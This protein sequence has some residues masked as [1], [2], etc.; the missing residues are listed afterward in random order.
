MLSFISRWFIFSGVAFLLL[1]H[2]LIGRSNVLN[3]DLEVSLS[4]NW[5]FKLDPENLGLSEKWHLGNLDRSDWRK[6]QIPHTWQVEKGTEEYYGVAWY[7]L[8]LAADPLWEG[9]SIWVH[10]ESI[11]RDALVWVNGHLVAEHMGSGWTPFEINLDDV[12]THGEENWVV[13]RV[14]N[15]FSERALPYLDSSDWAADG[16]IIRGVH[17]RVLPFLHIRRIRVQGVPAQKNR[18][19]EISAL[20]ELSEAFGPGKKFEV[21][22]DVFGPEGRMQARMKTDLELPDAVDSQLSLS[23]R[24]ENPDLWHFDHPQLYTL[25]CRLYSKGE[26]IHQREADFGIRKIEVRGGFYLLNGEP[27]R[28]M[29]LEWMPGSDPR[30]GMAEPVSVSLEVL[31]DLKRLNTV[32]TR[33]HWQQADAIYDFCDREGILVQEEVPAWGPKTMKGD[34]G[35]VQESQMREMILAHY[36]HPSIYAWGLCNE[37]GGQRPAAH[38]FVQRG[39]DIARE[40]DSSRLLTWASNT[41]QS[42]PEEDASKLVDFMEWNDYWE[43]WYGGGLIDLEKNLGEIKRAF[44]DKSLVISEYGLCE[45]DPKNPSGDDRRIE[46]LESHTN[47]YR[48]APNVAGAIF[49]SYNDYRTHIGDKS[50]GSFRQRV[51]G[52]VDL[53]GRPKPSWRV[54]RRESSPVKNL[55]VREPEIQERLTRVK[56]ELDTRSLQNDMPAYTLREYYLIWVVYNS[57]DQPIASGKI[58]LPLLPPGARHVEEIGWQTFRDLA[59]VRVEV[60]RPTGYSVHDSEWR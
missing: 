3:S 25:R 11:Y 36:N 1:S 41:L 18:E 52:V 43:S 29:G 48:K 24:I 12:W 60:F 27:M 55:L 13:V 6:I 46:I 16:G 54:L 7:A 51:H 53:L 23:A 59:L 40:L 56:I 21:E 8:S 31:R 38:Q 28:L 10:F 9:S 35:R 58:Q 30:F 26:L 44:P 32:I 20:I 5:S 2:T 37:I 39:V 45:C 50:T 47:L 14:D 17:L 15:Q 42:T 34:L 49:F 19:A 4:G 33:F 22:A 57:L